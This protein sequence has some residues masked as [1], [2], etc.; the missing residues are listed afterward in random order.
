MSFDYLIKD[1]VF[2]HTVLSQIQNSVP[3]YFVFPAIYILYSPTANKAYIGE[4]VNIVNRL[5]QHMAN[6]EKNSL[7]NVKVIFSHYFNKSSVLDIESNLIQNMQADNTFEL[8]NGNQGIIDH[9]YY[10]KELYQ[11]TFRQIWDSLKF[12]KIVKNDLL[13][14]Q[15]SDLFKFSPYKSLSIDQYEAIREYLTLLLSD[16][17]TQSIFVEGAAGTGKTVL[18]IYLIKLLAQ[19]ITL[20]DLDDY[21]E[22][23]T[24]IELAQKVRAKLVGNRDSIKIGLVIPMTSLRKTLKKVFRSIYGLTAAMVI[25]PNEV[26]KEDFDILIVDESH[27]LKQRKNIAGY[28]EFDKTNKHF[29][30]DNTGTELDWVLRST[31]NALFFYD[32]NQSIRPS[33]IPQEKFTILKNKSLSIS[34]SSQMRVKGG[35]NY[36]RFVDLL[37]SNSPRIEPWESINYS[38]RLFEFLPDMIQALEDKESKYGLCRMISGYS[39]KWISKKDN[40]MPDA[41]IDGVNLFWNKTNADW[42][43]STTAPSEMGCIH[44]TQGYDLNYAGIIFGSDIIFNPITERIEIIKENYHDRNGKVGIEEDALHDYI[45]NIYKTIM[46]RGIRGTYI[47]CYDKSLRDYFKQFIP[48]TLKESN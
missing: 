29:G 33:D 20:D 39:W 8:L 21:S 12:Q 19:K 13:D 32:S 14:I 11:N 2:D 47:Y 45:I 9:E 46:Y 48:I 38:L 3:T 34:L 4:S 41:T 37:L 24:L 42:I 23:T 5:K 15:N 27:R 26:S 7:N 36:I 17:E 35:E 6:P 43:N 40:N 22:D 1:F 18:A 30:L 10:Q 28:R 44:T 25:G 31:K 16:T